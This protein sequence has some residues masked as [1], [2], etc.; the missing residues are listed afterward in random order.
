MDDISPVYFS[1]TN[2]RSFDTNG[3]G[4]FTSS[5]WATDGDGNLVAR[6][7]AVGTIAFDPGIVITPIHIHG[8][9]AIGG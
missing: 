1:F 6:A 5:F 2:H 7:M 3:D 9:C 4:T 8:P